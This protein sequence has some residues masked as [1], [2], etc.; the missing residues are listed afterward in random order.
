[1]S[2]DTPPPK[3]GFPAV[4]VVLLI[5]NILPEL[6]LQLSDHGVIGPVTMRDAVYRLGAFQ[7]DLMVDGGQVFPGQILSMFFTYGFIHTGSL[8]L[9]IN[10][11]GLVWLARLIL[12]YRTTGTFVIFYLISTVGAAEFFAVFGPPHEAIAG[13]S[14]ALFGLLGVYVADRGML[15]THNSAALLLRGL[16]VTCILA[17]A[18]IL[19]QHLTGSAVAWQAHAGGFMTGVLFAV[20]A[21]PRYLHKTS[22]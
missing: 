18:D 8:H 17:F 12:S 7:R 5:L 19:N 3:P 20:V 9:T 21:P 13:A 1:M 22:V 14:G 6:L 16:V 4:L 10:M 11:I 15:G 2:T